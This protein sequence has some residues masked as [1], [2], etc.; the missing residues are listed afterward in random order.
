MKYGR[1][2][3][4]KLKLRQLKHFEEKIRFDGKAQ[5]A[6][7]LVWD[8]FFD[9]HDMA[10]GH[11]KY[12]L[13][14][15]SAM[16]KEEYKAVIDAY[17]AYMYYELYNESSSESLRG[18]YDPAILVRLGLPRDA[19]EPDIKQKFRELAKI[20]HP[21]TGGDAAA[22]IELMEIYRQLIAKK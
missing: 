14:K 22:F 19:A 15:L 21:D 1:S 18:E 3:E 4:I 8:R 6:G 20:Y 12:A 17:L 10:Q 7:K 9:I 11:A 13:E 16:S 5:P 2:E